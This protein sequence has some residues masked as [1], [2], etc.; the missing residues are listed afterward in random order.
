[1]TKIHNIPALINSGEVQ[2]YH[3]NRHF[4]RLGQTLSQHQ[5]ECAMLGLHF[6]PALPIE[7]LIDLLTHDVGEY[8]V[9]DSP[10]HF[11]LENPNLAAMQREIEDRT[12][13]YL[14]EHEP[15][16][17]GSDWPAFI[18]FIDSL[19]AYLYMLRHK[20]QI[21]NREGFPEQLSDLRLRAIR[22]FGTNGDLQVN[23]LVQM[24]ETH[25]S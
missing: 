10:Y 24:W 17:L 12:R 15:E 18:K 9:G 6:R 1:M 25:C 16:Y 13:H 23:S 5:W 19:S 14:I 2:R 4:A 21:K 20:P 22:L 8:F 11:K 3:T 7:V